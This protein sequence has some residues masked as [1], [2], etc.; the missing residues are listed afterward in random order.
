VATTA[1]R[2]RTS[3]GWQWGW[4]KTR[5]NARLTCT[6]RRLLEAGG[7]IP[8][9]AARGAAGR[10]LATM[11]QLASGREEGWRWGFCILSEHLDAA[12][13]DMCRTDSIGASA[14]PLSS[15]LAAICV[16]SSFSPPG[17]CELVFAGGWRAARCAAAL[18]CLFRRLKLRVLFNNT[19]HEGGRVIP[20]MWYI[21]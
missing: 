9:N 17:G 6:Q 14:L 11:H 21:S 1:A 20:V 15:L 12:S 10:L 5:R 2:R 19:R 3:R 7:S 13:P 16:I 18:A 8:Q 4:R